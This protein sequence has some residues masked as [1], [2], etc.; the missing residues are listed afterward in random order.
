MAIPRTTLEQ[1]RVLQAIVEYGGY[2][3]AAEA[4]HRSQSSISYMVAR[5]QE[6]LGV[7]LLVIEGRKAQL[8]ENGKALLAEAGDLLNE[9]R[10]LEQRAKTLQQGMETE[11]SLTVDVAFPTRLLLQALEQFT[12][13]AGPTRLQLNE[14][15]LS[16]AD[17]ALIAQTADVVIGTR[18]PPGFF[19]DLI[20]DVEMIAVA[21]P[22]HPLNA[23]GRELSSDDLRRH[24]QVVLR[25]SGSHQP[26]DDGWLA[27]ER[28]WTV[29]GLNTSLAM[30]EAGLG[31]AW[32]PRH[33]IEKR[34]AQGVLMRLRLATGGTRR[35]PLFLI[36]AC[37]ELVGP[38]TR[39][40]AEILQAVVVENASEDTQMEHCHE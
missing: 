32:L 5:L 14:E 39:K 16:G 21:S 37:P 35:V 25:D 40:L 29:T 8:T 9:A 17:E 18:V 4:L 26:R 28:R 20:F 1:W 10:K 19:G 30:V 34:I 36:F 23:L 22:S 24:L 13:W 6:Q 15:V 11:V 31:Y 3:Q 12:A 27:A 7:D 38:A 33:I 2:A